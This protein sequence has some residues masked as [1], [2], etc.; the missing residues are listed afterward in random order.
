MRNKLLALILALVMM[1]GITV[2]APVASIAADGVEAIGPDTV[3]EA[4][5]LLMTLNI[6]QGYEDGSLQLDGNI[7]RAEFAAMLARTL[8]GTDELNL[9]AGAI[10]NDKMSE[11]PENIAAVKAAEEKKKSGQTEEPAEETP[12][13]ENTPGESVVSAG[14]RTYYT[15]IDASKI[16]KEPFSDV[17]NAHWSYDDV[18]FLRSMA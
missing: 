13:D 3:T 15:D 4:S 11:T 14:A 5:T 7:T 12:A 1:V 6:L 2:M 10:L 8:R 16:V 18:E 9:N 17:T